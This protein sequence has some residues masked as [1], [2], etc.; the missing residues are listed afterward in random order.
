MF[1]YHILDAHVSFESFRFLDGTKQYIH[2]APQ[3]YFI[4][5]CTFPL[6]ISCATLQL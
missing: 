5:D 6:L 4:S 3:A 2:P 1:C